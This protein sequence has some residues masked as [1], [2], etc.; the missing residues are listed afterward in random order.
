[1]EKMETPIMPSVAGKSKSWMDYPVVAPEA[2]RAKKCRSV[3][4]VINPIFEACSEKSTDP[5][6]SDLFRQAAQGKFPK[7]FYYREG[8][9]T[10]KRISKIFNTDVPDNPYEAI[11]V[12]KDFLR[13]HRGIV[14]DLDQKSLKQRYED[15]VSDKLVAEDFKSLVKIKKIRGF[16]ID[17]YIEEKSQELKLKP[18]EIENLRNVIN[19]ALILKYIK[20]EQI[21][22]QNNRIINI[23]GLLFNGETNS[24]Y[25]DPNLIRKPT[26]CYTKNKIPAKSRNDNVP[27]FYNLWL[28]YLSDL[29]KKV[30]DK[31]IKYNKINILGKPPNIGNG[32]SSPSGSTSVNHH[33]DSSEVDNSPRCNGKSL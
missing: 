16:L 8:I 22:I 4:Q 21:I 30:S 32:S 10:Y 6:W 13:K 3:K 23:N 5:F 18:K 19:I 29:D 11:S 28:T 15:N 12:C 9:L 25:L 7:Y 31:Q 2:K 24:F 14:S 1:M 33:D 20:N 17:I 27:R 26:R